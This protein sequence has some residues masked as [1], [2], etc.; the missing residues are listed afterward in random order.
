MCFVV[1]RCEW[2]VRVSVR[3]FFL[4]NLER[5]DGSHSLTAM[6]LKLRILAASYVGISVVVCCCL[7]F[8]DD[9]DAVDME[10]HDGVV[11]LLLARAGRR[12]KEN[13][14]RWCTGNGG[15]FGFLVTAEPLVVVVPLLTTHP[16]TDRNACSVRTAAIRSH[17]MTSKLIMLFG[18]HR[19]DEEGE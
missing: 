6:M 16:E 14:G 4:E 18:V 1:Q 3:N 15:A 10:R 17:R 7:A 12:A 11:L 8:D 5:D 19:R 13:K 9:D 2:G